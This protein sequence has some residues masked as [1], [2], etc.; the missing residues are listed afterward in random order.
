VISLCD[1]WHKLPSEVLGE[2]PELLRYLEIVRLGGYYDKKAEV[3]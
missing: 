1:R 3:A 2:G